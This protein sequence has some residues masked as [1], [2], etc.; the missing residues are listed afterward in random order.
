MDPRIR[1]EGNIKSTQSFHPY[2][3]GEPEVVI[4]Y[5]SS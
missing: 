5:L 2:E 4:T 1:E 3:N